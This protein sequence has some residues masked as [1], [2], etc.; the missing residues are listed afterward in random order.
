QFKSL[1]YKQEYDFTEVDRIFDLFTKVKQ[2]SG[3]LTRKKIEHITKEI[4]KDQKYAQAIGE[5]LVVISGRAGTGKTIKLLTIACNL[6]ENEGARSLILTYNHALVSDIK[7]TLALAEI[8][9]DVDKYSVNITTLHKFIYELV[10]GFGLVSNPL[11]PEEEAKYIP[12]FISKYQGY[13]QELIDC[14][15]NGLIQEKEIQ[16]L[17][18]SKHEKVAW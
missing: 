14:I 2:G 10:L 6:A 12:D 17:M 8:P 15:E 5:K 4:L 18:R 9:D 3:D 1:N 16:E 13:L 11:N 7:R